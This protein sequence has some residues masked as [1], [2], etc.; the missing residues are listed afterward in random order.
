MRLYYYDI[1]TTDKHKYY[2]EIVKGL[3]YK[4][5]IIVLKGLTDKDILNECINAVKFDMPEF[6][7]VNFHYYIY[8][9]HNDYIEY[10]PEYLY[11]Y[12]EIENKKR[13]LEEKAAKII[14]SMPKNRNLSIYEKCLWLHNYL[15]RN[16]VYNQDAIKENADIKSAYCVEGVLLEETAVCQGIAMAYRYLCEK[17]DIE[18][19]V[20]IGYSLKPGNKKY[21]RHAWNIVRVGNNAI[22]VDVTWDMCLTDEDGPVRYD[23]FFLPDIEML[24]DHQYVKYPICRNREINYFSKKNRWF[25][26]EEELFQFIKNEDKFI[27]KQ[28]FFFYF[29]LRNR[30]I[31]KEELVTLIGK[32]LMNK[33]NKGYSCTY[34]VNDTQSVFLFHYCFK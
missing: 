14:N 12:S 21:E 18:A 29:K 4:S 32:L 3:R 16:C 25:N 20:A 33:K 6:F 30:K 26:S 11:S 23:Y 2:D 31:S 7:Y 28:D 22:H 34:F 8:K 24:R 9:C 1:L 13:M 19:I 10:K 5:E 17:I 15:A 27:I